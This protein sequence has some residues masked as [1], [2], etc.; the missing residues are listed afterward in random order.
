MPTHQILRDPDPDGSH[1]ITARRGGKAL[2][3]ACAEL[4]NKLR[5]RLELATGKIHSLMLPR[6]G[7]IKLLRPL[8]N[9]GPFHP[10]ATVQRST[11]VSPAF[12]LLPHIVGACYGSSSTSEWRQS[13]FVLTSGQSGLFHP[14]TAIKRRLARGALP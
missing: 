12:K 4:V 1:D 3:E 7:R 11:P 10:Q 5:R 9:I 13:G 14:I 6:L 2:R 8:L